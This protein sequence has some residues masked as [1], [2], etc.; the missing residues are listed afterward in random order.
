MYRIIT[1]EREYGCGAGQIARQLSSKLGWKLWDRE[2]TAEI[3]RVA[4][5]D[6]S[7]VSMCE[8]RVDSAFQK[9]VKVFWRGSYER[10]MHL[11]HQPF[12]PDRMVEVGEQVMREIAEQGNCVIVGRG[13]PYFLRDR[14]DVF[15]VF[16]YAPRGEKLR[17][18]QEQGRSLQDAEDLVDSVDRERMLFIKHYFGAD[19]P[20]RSL[21]HMM[22]NTALGDENVISM[23]LHSMRTLD[24]VPA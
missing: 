3:A 20:T 22:I 12:G 19:W 14:S 5:V 10:S 21:Y 1:V 7:A 18:I 16:L 6:S 9:L 2:L 15:H 24:H 11:E 4:N 23:I 8:E 13:A 17:R